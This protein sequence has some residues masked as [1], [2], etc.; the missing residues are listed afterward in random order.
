MTTPSFNKKRLIVALFAM[1]GLL[2]STHIPQKYMPVSLNRF[3][4][5]K[6]LHL[7]AYGV[8]AGLMILAIKP[9]RGLITK[10]GVLIA[11]ILLAIADECTQA[12]VGRSASIADLQ[13]DIIGILIAMTLT[14]AS[15]GYVQA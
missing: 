5:D 1:A 8:L 2:V 14:A 3:D 6:L 4:L 11:L 10:L 7:F 13:A 9:P 15:H 12:F